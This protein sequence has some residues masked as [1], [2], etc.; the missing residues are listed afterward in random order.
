MFVRIWRFVTLMFVA[1]SMAM[2]FAHL[3]QMPPRMRF[4]GPLWL[5]SQQLF[6]YF[7]PPVGA[8]LESGA[9]ISA[10]ILCILVSR[11]RAAFRWTLAAALLVVSAHVLWWWYVN[12]A[13]QQIA[14]WTP[15]TLPADWKAWRAQWEY[16]HAA[17]AILQIVGFAALVISVLLETPGD[18]ARPHDVE[19]TPVTRTTAG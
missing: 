10:V 16:T 17:R 2:A 5:H 18:P 11:R 19:I 1:L 9:W 12:P 6:E 4:D 14:Q 8:I 13:N 3:L 15:E 7:G